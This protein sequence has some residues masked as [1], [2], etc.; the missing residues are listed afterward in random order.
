MRQFHSRHKSLQRNG[1]HFHARSQGNH[2]NESVRGLALERGH[3]TRERVQGSIARRIPGNP[4]RIKFKSITAGRFLE[5]VSDR[6]LGHHWII[7]YSNKLAVRLVKLFNLF[8]IDIIDR[9][10]NVSLLQITFLCFNAVI[11][12]KLRGISR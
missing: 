7:G 8:G 11:T 10:H 4:I 12:L 5:L 1:I 9:E 6:G 3:A 2:G